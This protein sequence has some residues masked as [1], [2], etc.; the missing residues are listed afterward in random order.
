MP[1]L[2]HLSQFPSLPNIEA[3]LSQ[4]LQFVFYNF[5]LLTY[6]L[7][8]PIF[9]LFIWSEEE[10]KLIYWMKAE[11]DEEINYFCTMKILDSLMQ[12]EARQCNGRGRSFLSDKHPTNFSKQPRVPLSVNAGGRWFISNKYRKVRIGE[13]NFAETSRL[14]K[15]RARCW[16]LVRYVLARN[17]SN[18]CPKCTSQI[19]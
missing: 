11:R 19:I 9:I 10:R 1:K 17:I 7:G 6:Q 3:T 14:V 5:L 16:Q 13:S 4:L 8:E 12:W 18:G 15:L 2:F